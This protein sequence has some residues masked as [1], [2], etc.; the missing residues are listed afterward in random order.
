MEWFIGFTEGD[1]SFNVPKRILSKTGKIRLSLNF[2]V[3]QT[4]DDVQV[5]YKIKQELG[6][7]KILF[8]TEPNRN[9]ATYYVTGKE[10]F[11]RII[12][13]FNGNIC[14]EY[15][16]NQFKNWVEAYNKIYNEKEVVINNTNKIAIF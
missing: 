15:R 14:S 2:T 16:F 13:I 3:C 11:S 7:G 12:S 8:Q 5:L 4:L 1:G 10:N 6:M 9:L